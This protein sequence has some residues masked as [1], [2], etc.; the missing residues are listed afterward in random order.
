MLDFNGR[1]VFITGGSRGVGRAAA[2]LFARAGADVAISYYTRRDAAEAVVSEIRSLGRRAVAVGGEHAD[3]SVVASMFGEIVA[4][5]GGLD[6]FVANAG[7]WPERDVPLAELPASRWAETLRANLDGVYLTT[8]GALQVLRP[9]GSIVLVSSTAGQRGE[10]F[11][12][13][14]AVT[15]G[16]LIALTKSLA[17]ECAPD[18]TVNCCAPGWIDT[19]M[20]TGV[21]TPEYRAR[22]ESSIPLG[23]IATADDVAWPILFLASPLARHITGE[24]LNVN[25]GSVLCG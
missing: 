10:A 2:L 23:R 14:Y 22:V 8:R 7:I 15:K 17:I 21:L 4:A 11:H 6:I 16:G 24:V 25:G 3:E 20:T 1:S 18:I 9:G 5:L 12:A 19:D 13:D